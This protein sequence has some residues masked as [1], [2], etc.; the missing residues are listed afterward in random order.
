MH[1]DQFHFSLF[2]S[3]SEERKYKRIDQIG[4]IC[5]AIIKINW[6]LL[7]ITI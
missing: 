5:Q 3:L 6:R 4:L 7:L 1:D 2:D